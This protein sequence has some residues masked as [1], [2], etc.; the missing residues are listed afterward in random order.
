MKEITIQDV[1]NLLSFTLYDND[2]GSILRSFEGF[3]FSEINLT[4]E[5]I[6]DNGASY[7]SSKFGKRRLSITGD[8]ISSTVY[9]LRQQLLGVLRQTGYLKLLKF[10]TYDDLALQCYVDIVKLL[11]PYTHSIHTFLI[12]A[13]AP[14]WRFYSQTLNSSTITSSST[15]VN[16][17][18]EYTEP[19]FI[20]TGPGTGFTITNTTTGESFY[21]DYTLIA[22]QK[23]NINITEKTVILDDITNIYDK[24]TGDFFSLA[25]GN[26]VITIA[27]DSGSG[28]QT[29]LIT[30][31]RDAY[32]GI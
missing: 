30:S 16:A 19:T 1:E 32:R 12:E 15:L 21:I 8:L 22:G 29:S 25:P 23:I 17:G 6:A 20:I 27:V 7:A 3:E 31:W 10:T 5:D 9:T 4:I 28:V 24:I 18:N 26:N 14:D 13:I 2:N 11:N